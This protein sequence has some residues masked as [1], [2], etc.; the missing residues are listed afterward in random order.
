MK[1]GRIKV[2]TNRSLWILK[3]KKSY[4]FSEIR[5][6]EQ[7][8]LISLKIIKSGCVDLEQALINWRIN[9]AQHSKIK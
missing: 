2:T 3:Y 8:G 4:T 9:V 5:G 7:V 1:N 6:N